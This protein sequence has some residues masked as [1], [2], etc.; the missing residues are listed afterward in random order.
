L[1]ILENK[2]GYFSDGGKTYTIKDWRTP[3]PWI[4]VISNGTWGL[5]ISQTGGGYS[6]HTHAMFNRITRWNQDIIQD[7]Y[8]KYFFLRD[9]DKK[10]V[11]SLTPQPLKPDFENYSCV[12]GP[13]YTEFNVKISGVE[14]KTTVFVPL[15]M[16][17]EIWEVEVKNTAKK[18]KNLTL[19]NYME[20]LLGAFPD[21]HR[22]F[23]KTFI[24][25]QYS[26]KYNAILANN[27]LWTAPVD[28]D[29]SWNKDWH[30]TAFFMSD[31]APDHYECDKEKFVGQYNDISTAAAF[32]ADKLTDTT[33]TG[34]D[35]AA[36]YQF[37][38]K[39]GPG[40]VKKVR[41]CLG[42]VKKEE[43][44]KELPVY[45]KKAFHE[46]EKLKKQ[47]E[48]HWD[49]IFDKL[50]VK[51]PDPAV[52]V[53]INYWLKYQSISC[54]LLGR[55]AY[56]QCGGAFG[57]RDQLQ[58]S[59]IYLT[60]DPEKT[61]KQIEDHAR[62]QR[63]DGIVQHWWHPIANEGHFNGISDNLLW[64]AFVTFNY[65]K[66]TCDFDFLKTKVDFIDG[67]GAP[68]LD[69]VKKAIDKA[70][71]RRSPR[72]LSLIG[73]GDWNDGLNAV[74][75]EWK[76]ESIWLSNF[77]Y[78]IIKDFIEVLKKI[79]YP[80]AKIKKYEAE[81]EKLKKAV[82]KHGHEKLHFYCATKDNGE[83]IGAP[84]AKECELYLNSQTWAVIS[85]ITEGESS[86]KV[87][88]AVKKRL[89]K[90]YGV[91]LFTPAFSIVDKSVGYLTRY[92]P[93]VRENGGVYTHAATWAII[94]QAI[95]GNVEDV[96][97]T[98]KRICPPLLSVKN[99]DKYKGEPYVT[100]GNIEGPESLNE[101]QGAWTWYS[102]SSGWL[103]KAVIER[104]LG[105]RVEYGKL[106][107]DPKLPASWDGFYIERI[108]NGKKFGVSVKKPAG[109]IVDKYDVKIKEI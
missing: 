1:R 40:A 56:Y 21:W 29:S 67:G 72:G 68:V 88:A 102:G 104:L 43:L 107:V 90:D 2:Y 94:A 32:K 12:H 95:A 92:A 52:D 37:N 5:T 34:F 48:E 53:M 36:A 35:Q 73:E 39:L 62:H 10:E 80:S 76:G 57:F 86:K 65:L 16:A 38:F 26:S 13:G 81:S 49:Q 30:Y 99:P 71:E 75:P 91:L 106:V 45:F 28:G 87:L 77:L 15:D 108:V 47:I 23:T 59:Q 82:L 78:G 74:G 103:Y 18:A 85:G 105:V 101:G 93:G 17:C 31:T 100:P 41:Y 44:K 54:R 79:K 84:G 42:A 50:K 61:R 69:H 27:K 98:F 109:K 20:L 7:N 96:Y 11:H 51:T 19:L 55:T 83:I 58:D 4:N 33:G 3:K 14:I 9:N 89:Y 66:E 64:L 22:E 46:T 63:K 70:L 24:T 25:T 8:G 97:D 60:L 6:W